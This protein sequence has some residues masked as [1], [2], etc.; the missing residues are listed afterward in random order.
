MAELQHLGLLLLLLS[1]L[2]QLLPILRATITCG[3][4]L[5]TKHITLNGSLLCT[6]VVRAREQDD[7]TIHCP[8][9]TNVAQG[10]VEF[11]KGHEPQLS[12]LSVDANV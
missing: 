10:L 2:Q 7:H 1:R 9:S 6:Y 5:C 8:N 11:A 12:V 3:P 4:A